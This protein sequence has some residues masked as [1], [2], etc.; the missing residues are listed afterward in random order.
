MFKVWGNRV[1]IPTACRTK[2]LEEL[3]QCHLGIHRMKALAR[4]YLWWP[5]LDKDLENLVHNCHTCQMHPNTPSKAIHPWEWSNKPWQRIHMDYADFH[6]KTYLIV[7]D[8]YSKWLEVIP[9]RG[10][11]TEITVRALRKIFATHQDLPV[12]NL[13]RSCQKMEYATSPPHLII[14]QVTG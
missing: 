11:S 1:I 5:H 4:S 9:T 6:G 12:K 7:V 14:H 3:H 13:P 8:S 10:S 2:V